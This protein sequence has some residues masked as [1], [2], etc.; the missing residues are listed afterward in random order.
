MELRVQTKQVMSVTGGYYEGD[1]HFTLSTQPRFIQIKPPPGIKLDIR[2]NDVGTKSVYGFTATAKA[3]TEDE[4]ENIA[5]T[6]AK[7]FVD[8]LAYHSGGDLSYHCDGSSIRPP[9][10]MTKV[11]K[12]F[13]VKYDIDSPET[14]DLS[15]GNF[16]NLIKTAMLKGDHRRLADRLSHINN[17]L[18]AAKGGRSEVMI[19]EFYLAIEDKWKARKHQPLRHALSH[20]GRLKP[21]TRKKLEK[22]FGKG[23]FELPNGIFDHS[24]PKNIKHLQIQANELRN[25]AMD[26][27]RKELEKQKLST[28]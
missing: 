6:M 27:I 22:N 23:Y 17:G 3:S 25:I 24:S 21:W 12:E 18:E 7:K 8:S 1:F 20:S 4:I 5:N 13:I 15:Q 19:K 10:G 26:Y 16:A 2:D 14:I 28:P 9:V 11:S